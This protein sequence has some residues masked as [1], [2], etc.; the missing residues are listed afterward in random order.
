MRKVAEY[1]GLSLE[2]LGLVAESDRSIDDAID[3]E[4]KK[5]AQQDNLVIDS[6][7][8]YHWIPDA[9][10]VYLKLD[11]HIAAERIHNHIHSVG[12]IG[13]SAGTTEEIYEKMTQRIE[14]EKKRYK[15]HYDNDYTNEKNFDLVVDTGENSLEQVAKIILDAYKKWNLQTR[16][17]STK[18]STRG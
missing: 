18:F 11:P 5:T 14:S 7:L 16:P 4:I 13:Q 15:A 6:R 1:R 8:A 10:K 3:D 17:L 9:F 12:R 2:D